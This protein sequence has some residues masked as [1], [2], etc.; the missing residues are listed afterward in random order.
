MDNTA[1]TRRASPSPR[2]PPIFSP[3]GDGNKDTLL[4]KL[5]G[6]VEDLWSAQVADAS[7][8]AVRT[9]KFENAAPADWTWD[10]K[11][12]DGKVVPDGVYSF[13]IS[14][15]RQGRQLGL[16]ALRQHR[17]QH[18]AAA[19][20]PRDRP[21][22]PSAPT[23]TASKDVV[24]LF[25]SVPV[26]TG[27]VSAGSSRSS[28][29]PSA[30]SGPCPART[31]PRSPTAC[32]ST[33]A[34]SRRLKVLPEGQYQAQ[35]SVTYLNGYSP[36]ASSPNFIL[37]VTPPSGSVERRSAGLQSRGRPGPEQRPL[38][39]EGR[40]GRQVDGRGHRAPTARSCGPTP[41][42]P[43]PTPTSSGTAPTTRASPC[44]TASTPTGSRP[45]TT[46]ATPSPR[47]PSRSRSTPPRR[48]FAS[49]PTSRP[50]APCPAA[51]RTGSP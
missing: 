9:L 44:P 19:H 39:A 35:L 33:A 41:S 51:R 1:P 20:R 49:S 26:K 42:R 46:R 24:T 15:H 5:S 21:R 30:R 43:C 38:P 25:P 40:Q 8:K 37:D 48:R 47:R 11:G 6:S 2:I 16:Q 28:T 3:D 34:T 4:I 10:G 13:S 50:S 18:P 14:S 31:A 32:P 23:A 27:I 36:K 7:G 12:D 29:R 17:R 45:W 22:P